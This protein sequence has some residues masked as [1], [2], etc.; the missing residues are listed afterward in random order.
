MHGSKL[1]FGLTTTTEMRR[2]FSGCGYTTIGMHPLTLSDVRVKVESKRCP[3]NGN[4]CKITRM[5]Y[6]VGTIQ[7]VSGTPKN[8]GKAIKIPLL[9]FT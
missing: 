9:L 7:I 5:L 1:A 3:I 8:T 4:A 6:R 2:L